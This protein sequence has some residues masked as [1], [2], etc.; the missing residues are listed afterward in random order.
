M[1]KR[2]ILKIIAAGMFIAATFAAVPA[3]A[4]PGDEY[5]RLA[6]PTKQYTIG[7][8]L[9]QLSNPHFVGQAYGYIDEAEKLGV[10]VIMFDAG[11]YQYLDRQISQMEDLIASKVDA[12]ILVAVNGPGTVGA[13]EHAVAAGIPVINCN[14]MT[15]S[16]KVATRVR[17]DDEVIGQM[18]ADY[19]GQS[20]KGEG[21]VVMLRGAPGTS[22]AE[23]RGN[24]FK[25]RLTE[26]F[27][28]VTVVGEQYSQSTPADGLKLMEDFLQTF[29]QID[30]A[31]NG[32]DTTAIGAAQAVLAAGKKG[33]VTITATDF[34]VDTQKFI[35]DGV[36][37]ATVAQQT[38]IIGRWGVRAAIN[39]LE[40]REVP[41]ALWTPLLLVSAENV[42]NLDLSTLRAPAG[43][44]PPTR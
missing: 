44:K 21:K 24:A 38:V 34:Q 28:K 20:L 9:P 39:A 37:G 23:N 31:Y 17:S 41:K 35:H 36:M 3:K 16:D 13:V 11:G 6:K 43:W 7:V 40:K 19:M 42:D 12:I 2:L 25:K 29:P 22:W 18:Q 15:A 8:L 14:V 27:P 32:A 5:A 30:G 1:N 33:K 10:K 26:K 4:E